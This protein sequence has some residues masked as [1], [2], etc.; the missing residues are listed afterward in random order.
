MEYVAEAVDQIIHIAT[1]IAFKN[2]AEL[3]GAV[4]KMFIVHYHF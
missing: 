2:R 1:L 4:K 3:G